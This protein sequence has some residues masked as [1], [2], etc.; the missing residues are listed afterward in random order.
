MAAADDRTRALQE[1]AAI[2]TQ[3]GLSAAEIAA[4]LRSAAAT[5]ASAGQ[6]ASGRDSRTRT[7]LVRA[8]GYLGGT[9]VFAGIGVFIALQWGAMNSAARVVV[10]LGPG[11]VAFILAILSHRETRFDKITAPLFLMAAVLEPMGMLVAFEE[12]GSGGD[13]RI[14]SLITAGTMALQFGASVKV[15]RRSTPLFMAILFSVLFWW[16]ALDLLDVSAQTTALVIGGSVFLAAVGLDRT[17]HRDI[18]PFWYFLGSAAFLEGFFDLVDRTPFE[19]MF[20]AVAAGFV[21]LSVVLHSRALLIV[22]TLGILAYTGWFTRQHFADSVG[23]PIALIMF[24]AVMI[25]L[26]ALAFRIDRDYVR[27]S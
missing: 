7:V 12:F 2:A 6:A 10:T 14:A 26:S 17:A 23:W 20:I 24:G 19:I 21:Y 27:A 18:S 1:I 25:G 4:S 15:V 9:F 8:L 5:G 13:W 3:Y 16:T 22:A 11:V